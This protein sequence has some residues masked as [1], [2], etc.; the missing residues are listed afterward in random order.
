MQWPKGEDDS[1]KLRR[2]LGLKDERLVREEGEHG[3]DGAA[4]ARPGD[5]QCG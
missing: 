5:G 3:A 4:G 2:L 1:L